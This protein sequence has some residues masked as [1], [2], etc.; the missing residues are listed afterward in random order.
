M[1]LTITPSA[2]SP[3]DL[4]SDAEAAKLLRVST[5]TVAAYR[6]PDKDGKIALQFYRLPGGRS[7][8]IRRGDVMALLDACRNI[9]CSV[10]V[11]TNTT[12]AKR[13]KPAAK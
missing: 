11:P 6:K 7:V 12:T 4:L 9:P 8:R 1:S 10:A 2:P 3:D 5:N 13:R